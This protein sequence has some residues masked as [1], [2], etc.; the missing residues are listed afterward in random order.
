MEYT[1]SIRIG[2]GLAGLNGRKNRR[3]GFTL[4]ELTVGLIVI[5]IM[6]ALI[7]PEVKSSYQDALLRASARKLVNVLSLAYSRAV[8]SS[9]LHRVRID[10]ATRKYALEKPV[11]D[12]QGETGFVAVGDVSGSEG[13]IDKRIS[14][15]IHKG[16]GPGDEDE[17]DRDTNGDRENQRGPGRNDVIQFFPDGTA[18][19]A[20]VLLRDPEGFQLRLQVNPITGRVRILELGRE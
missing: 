18:D 8:T 7:I 9:Q 10:G 5:G 19:A 20:E 16:S 14:V 11:R 13:E 2:N 6:T 17:A 15:I 1:S 12:G 3:A 4:I